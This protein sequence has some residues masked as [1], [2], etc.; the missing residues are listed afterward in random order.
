MD[1]NTRRNGSSYM[2]NSYKGL[3][4]SNYEREDLMECGKTSKEEQED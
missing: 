3:R 2:Y 4:D 1:F